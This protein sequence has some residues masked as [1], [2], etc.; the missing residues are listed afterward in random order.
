MSGKYRSFSTRKHRWKR[1]VRK[2]DLEVLKFINEVTR[3]STLIPI[4]DYKKL[5][6]RIYY[7]GE[8]GEKLLAEAVELGMYDKVIYEMRDLLNFVADLSNRMRD[9]AQK[10]WGGTLRSFLLYEPTVA[11]TGQLQEESATIRKLDELLEKQ[12]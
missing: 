9:L 2:C 3:G 10:R 1:K 11:A 6:E 7:L 4:L 8:A 5:G 12:S